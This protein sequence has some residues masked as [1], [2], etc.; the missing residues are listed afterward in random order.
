M[1][2]KRPKVEP[3]RN[4]TLFE[5]DKLEAAGRLANTLRGSRIGVNFA[6][7]WERTNGN[8]THVR[9]LGSLNNNS[10]R[11]WTGGTYQTK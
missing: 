3:I 2:G 7:F 8:R 9:G 6:N 5:M 4:P 11:R 10:L 1:A